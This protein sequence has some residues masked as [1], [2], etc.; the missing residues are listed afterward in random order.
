MVP[1]K[2]GLYKSACV[3]I[4]V[5]ATVSYE[6]LNSQSFYMFSVFIKRIPLA[7]LGAHECQF[8]S[9]Q[10]QKLIKVVVLGALHCVIMYFGLII[11]AKC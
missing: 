11:H 10:L 2:A 8:A 6:I 4:N 5:Y 9:Q 3:S 7:P 1:L